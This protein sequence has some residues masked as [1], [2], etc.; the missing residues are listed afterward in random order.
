M[1]KITSLMKNRTDT[2]EIWIFDIVKELKKTPVNAE[3]MD[4]EGKGD[5]IKG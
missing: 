4:V 2:A 1:P 5:L 3:E